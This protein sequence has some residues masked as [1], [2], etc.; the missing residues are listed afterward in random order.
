MFKKIWRGTKYS[1]L[2]VAAVVA[3][4]KIYNYNNKDQLFN[5]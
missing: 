1:T 2:T 3:L 5:K 4:D